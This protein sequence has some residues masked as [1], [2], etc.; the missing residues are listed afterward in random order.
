[1]N[2]PFYKI[3]EEDT[4]IEE[5]SISGGCFPSR[6]GFITSGQIANFVL[7]NNLTLCPKCNCWSDKNY[8]TYCG[9]GGI[10]SG[11]YCGH[12]VNLIVPE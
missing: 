5:I 10:T 12:L 1:M 6:S 7:L 4:P 3:I 9:Q 11:W 2:N 8:C